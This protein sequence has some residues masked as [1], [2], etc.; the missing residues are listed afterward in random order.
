[1]Q[2]EWHLHTDSLHT[3]QRCSATIMMPN[4]QHSPLTF[5]ALVSAATFAFLC[6]PWPASAQSPPSKKATTWQ[7]LGFNGLPD[8]FSTDEIPLFEGLNQ[9]RGTWSFKGETRDGEAA[10]PVKGSL[11]I[12]GNPT[13]GML[14][15][16]TLAWNWAADD[17]ENAIHDT[18]MASPRQTGF[19]LMLFRIGPVTKPEPARANPKVN[20]TMFRGRWDS[21]TRTVVWTESDL[22]SRLG[23]KNA[24]FDA[25]KPKQTFE[26]LVASDGKLSI[27]NSHHTLKGQLTSGQVITRT[28]KAPAGPMTL[29]GKHSFKTVAEITDPRI[30]P[31]LPPQ[32]TEISLLSERGGHFARYKV[33]ETDFM[34]FLDQLW[35]AKQ[36]NSAHQRANMSGEGEPA[37]RERMARRFQAA[38]WEPLDNAVTY[39][40]PSKRNGAMTT[41]Y[42]DRQTGIAYHDTGYW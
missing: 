3:H 35:K 5:A 9:S 15:G 30:Q 1:M 11:Q 41:Y 25:S 42:Y 18:I 16:W 40:S 10:S 34:K 28:A 4:F 39:F 20:R 26:M 31:S 2:S 37:S 13:S 29:T 22:P 21:E 38:G 17:S 33:A 12:R 32:A 14:P 36:E 23:S 8:Q 19:A 27:H 24:E 6:T 7:D